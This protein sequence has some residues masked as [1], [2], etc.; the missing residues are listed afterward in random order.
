[1]WGGACVCVSHAIAYC[2]SVSRGLSATAEFLVYSCIICH[3]FSF[4]VGHDAW[5]IDWLIDYGKFLV[6]WITCC[7][8]S[9]SPQECFQYRFLQR[10]GVNIGNVLT[11][12][13]YHLSFFL[14]FMYQIA[15]WRAAGSQFLPIFGIHFYL[16][17]HPMSQNYQISHGNSWGR[18]LV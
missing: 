17:I 16:C 12:Y 13:Y 8:P 6:C 14:F 2:T 18:G 15:K 3:F 9:W 11:N 7:C 4:Y 5:L 1:M 10:Q